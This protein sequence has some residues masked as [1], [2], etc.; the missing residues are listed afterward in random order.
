MLTDSRSCFELDMDGQSNARAEKDCCLLN[1]ASGWSSMS[2]CSTDMMQKNDIH[3]QTGNWR[4]SALSIS[5]VFTACI[6]SGSDSQP[7]ILHL[8]NKGCRRPPYNFWV[9]WARLEVLLFVLLCEHCVAEDCLVVVGALAINFPARV[10]DDLCTTALLQPAST[11]S[12]ARSSLAGQQNFPRFVEQ[13]MPGLQL[14][15]Q[16]P[17]ALWKLKLRMWQMID[18]YVSVCCWWRVL[19]C[20]TTLCRSFIT[21][22]IPLGESVLYIAWQIRAALHDMGLCAGGGSTQWQV[23]CVRGFLADGVRPAAVRKLLTHPPGSWHS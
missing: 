11:I 1:L 6:M 14:I 22:V 13:S 18:G 12:T 20:L 9:E 7:A 15:Q 21:E 8:N 17:Y 2:S 4:E 5:S 3:K 23:L 19:L 16:V 10:L